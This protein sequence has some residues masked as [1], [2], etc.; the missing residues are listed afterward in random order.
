MMTRQTFIALIG[1]M[2]LPCSVAY[3]A[4]WPLYRGN[5]LA[6]GIADAKLPDNLKLEWEFEVKDG[7]F[8][9][10][11]VVVD[12]VAY[13]GDLDASV[14]A[15]KIAD[16]SKLWEY[17]GDKKNISG[18]LGSPA[19]R[20]G[21]IF[22]G[23]IDGALHCIDAKTGKQVWKYEAGLEINSSVNFYQDKV[24]IGSQ[25]SNLYCLNIAD[26]KL[27]WKYQIDDQIRCMPTVVANRG[28][29]AGCDAKL[30]VVDLDQGTK[31]GEVAIDGPTGSSPAVRDEVAY[32]GTE[33][34]S[35]YAIN[36]KS[37]K[38][39]WQYQ[40]PSRQQPIRASAAVLPDRVIYG[41]FNKKLVS[42]DRASGKL[43]WEFT[44]RGKIA[45]SPVVAGNRVYFGAADSRVR[46]LDIASGKEVWQFEARGEFPAGPAIAEN[47]LLIASDRGVVY[48]FGPAE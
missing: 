41:S 34:G 12:G 15:L 42:L 29:L 5:E 16:G 14:Y 28:F 36:W 22:V 8:E 43:Q 10:T 45:S 6:Q 46:A 23:D 2:L 33:G 11:P 27:A 48:C 20:D 37:L 31:A 25:D 40:D 38:I 7:A 1:L 47:R 3:S 32:F 9:A 39:D 17:E 18:F 30:H 35:F 21:K 13:I 24:L 26:G 19:Y 4:D 44:A